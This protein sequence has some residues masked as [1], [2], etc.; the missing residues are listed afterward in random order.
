MKK[1][2]MKSVPK[3]ARFSKSGDKISNLA[4]LLSILVSA[5][6]VVSVEFNLTQC[7][8]ELNETYTNLT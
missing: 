8:G 3:F 6:A 5:V 7:F 4:A 1:L 2:K